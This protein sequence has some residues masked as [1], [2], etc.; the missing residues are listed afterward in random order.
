MNKTAGFAGGLVH[1]LLLY[2]ISYV[3]LTVMFVSF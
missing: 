2:F 1:F 3:T